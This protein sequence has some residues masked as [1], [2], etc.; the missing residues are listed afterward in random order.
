VRC[1]D[2]FVADLPGESALGVVG[3]DDGSGGGQ[4]LKDGLQQ[5]TEI[6]VA[7]LVCTLTIDTQHL[8]TAAQDAQLRGRWCARNANELAGDVLR[9]EALFEM[10]TVFVVAGKAY[11]GISCTKVREIHGGVGG[12]TGLNVLMCCA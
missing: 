2:D 5:E 10:V 12:A 7:T 6:A 4:S 1:L 8:L 9:T 11:Y 3:E